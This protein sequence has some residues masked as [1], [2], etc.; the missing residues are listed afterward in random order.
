[1]SFQQIAKTVGSLF[2]LCC[3]GALSWRKVA[4]GILAPPQSPEF[5]QI[6]GIP[7]RPSLWQGRRD[8]ALAGLSYLL[9]ICF[10]RRIFPGDITESHHPQSLAPSPD[11]AFHQLQTTSPARSRGEPAGLHCLFVEFLSHSA[12]QVLPGLADMHQECRGSLRPFSFI[13][14]HR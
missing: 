13:R 8:E 2:G 10:W 5:L 9:T 6:A 3:R 7:V 11:Q 14:V 4:V 12:F 1:M